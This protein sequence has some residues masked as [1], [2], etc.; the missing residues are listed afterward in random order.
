M[1]ASPLHRALLRRQLQFLRWS[2]CRNPPRRAHSSKPPPP[3]EESVPIANTVPALPL[4]QRLGPLTRLAEA[5][6]RA[7]RRRPYVTQFC[8]S[9]VIYFC[10]DISAQRISGKDYSPERTA[11]SLVIG[12]ISSIPSYKWYVG[13]GTA[14]LYCALLMIVSQPDQNKPPC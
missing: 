12:G 8:T 5:Y 14:P 4:W 2:R 11:R 13:V 1:P 6:A 7:Q 10:A 3:A 9:L